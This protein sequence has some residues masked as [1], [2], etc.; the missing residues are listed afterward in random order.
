V[1][2]ALARKQCRAPVLAALGR[3][4]GVGPYGP[5]PPCPSDHAKSERTWSVLALAAVGALQLRRSRHDGGTSKCAGSV[6]KRTYQSHLW[7][8]SPK[9]R[10]QLAAGAMPKC[11]PSAGTHAQHA[12]LLVHLKCCNFRPT[13]PFD[14][15]L[16]AGCVMDVLGPVPGVGVMAK[17][18]QDG[19]VCV[20][21]H[22]HWLPRTIYGTSRRA[23]GQLLGHVRQLGLLQLL[24]EGNS[25][26][27]AN[28]SSKRPT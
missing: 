3:A 23:C 26:W 24:S 27:A 8:L 17:R 7:L 28:F 1:P 21:P 5:V 6:C 20:I 25:R 19:N 13:G 22:C 16:R 2:N 14:I 4:L 15:P 9:G 10:H 18:S 11:A 12:T